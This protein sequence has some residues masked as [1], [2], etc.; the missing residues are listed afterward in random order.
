MG[1]EIK[2]LKASLPGSTR[3]NE[4]EVEDLLDHY[5]NY[6]WVIDGAGITKNKYTNFASDVCWFVYN[7]NSNLKCFLKKNFDFTTSIKKSIVKTKERYHKILKEKNIDIPSN[8]YPS[9]CISAVKIDTKNTFFYTL[10]DCSIL[11]KQKNDKI[12]EIYDNRVDFFDEASCKIIKKQKENN[13]NISISELRPYL[14]KTKK[15]QLEM[16]NKKG[17]YFVIS[18]DPLVV[19]EFLKIKVKTKKI[20]S[21]LLMSDGLNCSYKKYKIFT[22]KELLNS[23]EKKNS[24]KYAITKTRHFEELDNNFLKA[25]R[26][27]TSDDLSAVYVSLKKLNKAI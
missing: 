7:I 17:G 12:F 14:K 27:K 5:Q 10:G 2:V 4:N 8:Q 11:Y 6:Y 23:I 22:K 26:T 3:K 1:K 16:K 20:N 24:L 19:K 21:I 13:P 15:R 18:D 25:P 9:A